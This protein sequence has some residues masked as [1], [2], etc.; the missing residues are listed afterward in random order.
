VAVRAQ[1]PSRRRPK[2]RRARRPRPAR[3]SRQKRAAP[4]IA[5]DRR[6][7]RVGR[8]ACRRGRTSRSDSS[9]PGPAA[10]ARCGPA[11]D[12]RPRPR[13]PQPRRSRPSRP[14]ARRRPLGRGRQ[15]SPAGRTK[16]RKSEPDAAKFHPH[17][18]RIIPLTRVA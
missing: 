2:T 1:K 7:W 10:S 3:R 13:R 18:M 6:E 14:S 17:A 15:P 12:I 4:E 11:A 8:L 5:R 9:P 16:K